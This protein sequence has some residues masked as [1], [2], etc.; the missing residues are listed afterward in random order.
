MAPQDQPSNHPGFADDDEEQGD[1]AEYVTLRTEWTSDEPV[2]APYAN[3]ILVQHTENEFFI[4]FG[5][6]IPPNTLH[7][8]QEDLLAIGKVDIHPVARIAISP[9]KMREFVEVISNNWS[10]FVRTHGERYGFSEGEMDDED[11]GETS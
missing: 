8:S 9:T 5:Q 2:P 1:G 4:T 11:S 6:I 3:T 7:Y 10:T